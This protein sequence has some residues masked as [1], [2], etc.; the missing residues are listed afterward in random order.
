MR[1]YRRIFIEGKYKI[2]E[3]AKTRYVLDFAE[4]EEPEYSKRRVKL[5]AEDLPYKMYPLNKRITRVAQIFDA[6]T[7][8]FIDKT[9]KMINYRPTKFLPVVCRRIVKTWQTPKGYFAI[10]VDGVASTFLVDSG[11]YDYAQLIKTNKGYILFD[12][13]YHSVKP[14]RKKI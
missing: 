9:G 5:L 11:G 10:K 1:K 2:I 8:L 12:V 7:R 4:H 13:L 3:T 14:T 6:K